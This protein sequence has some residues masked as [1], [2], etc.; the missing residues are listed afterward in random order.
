ML[1]E[2]MHEI[3]QEETMDLT[4]LPEGPLVKLL[5]T[6]GKSELLPM[7]RRRNDLDER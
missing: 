1:S 3:L 6:E 4:D 5:K 2:L 7:R